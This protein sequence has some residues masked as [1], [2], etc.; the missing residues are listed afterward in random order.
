MCRTGEPRTSDT[1]DNHFYLRALSLWQAAIIGTEKQASI[2]PV[3]AGHTIGRCEKR[4]G[5]WGC[6]QSR[7]LEGLNHIVTGAS[8]STWLKLHL[9]GD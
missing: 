1:L 4:P 6:Y 8:P 9:L 3:G 5:A 7:G 2:R